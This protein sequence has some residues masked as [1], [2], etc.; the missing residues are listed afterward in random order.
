MNT[1]PFLRTSAGP[2]TLARLVAIEDIR[3]LKSRYFAAVDVKDWRA[4]GRIFTGDARVDFSGECKHHV[5]HHGL[6][7]EGINPA[8]WVVIG[9][10]A[11]AKVIEGAAAIHQGH[12]PQI[13]IH[14]PETAS[15]GSRHSR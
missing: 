12:N 14:T 10:E 4:I 9:G 6:T 8:D 5:G 15:G 11:M 2:D 7:A 1:T 3:Q 13:Q